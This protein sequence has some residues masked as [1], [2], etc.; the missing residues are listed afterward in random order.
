M[1]PKSYKRGY[2]VAVLIGLDEDHAALWQ[3]FSQV[4]KHQQTI[5]LNGDRKNPKATYNYHESIINALRPTIKGGVRNIII[6]A[7]SKT[8]Y[9]QE[10]QNHVTAHHAWLLQGANKA[11]FSQLTGSASTPS[12]VAALTKTSTFKQLIQETAAEETENLLD[13]LEK[14]LNTADNLVLFSLEE[15]ENLILS[16][17]A[18]GKPQPE[19]LLL[20][21]TYLAGSRQKNRLHR[22]MQ[23]AQNKK[24]KTRVISAES[25]AGKRL[26][27]LGGIVCLAKTECF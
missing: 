7:P 15:A 22:L 24:V 17:Q 10:L 21:D 8:S 1:A 3:V 25:N 27:Q 11:T 16:K 5:P 9:A 14:R 26:T 23:I 13:I 20:T 2:P 4:A 18:P 6:A 19:Y 12:Q